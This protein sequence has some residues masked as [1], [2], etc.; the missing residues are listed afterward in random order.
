M[1]KHELKHHG[2]KGQKWG[3]RRYQNKDG[4]LTNAGKNRYND[5]SN[6]SSTT[7]KKGLTDKQ[8]KYLKIGATAVGVGLAAY[9]V[10]R[11]KK[12]GKL[13]QLVGKGKQYIEGTV[14][15]TFSKK[16]SSSSITKDLKAVNPNFKTGQIGYRM[17]CGNCSIAYEMR[18]RGFDTQALSNENGMKVASFGE[19][20]KGLKS[21]SFCELSDSAKFDII[22][23]DKANS[24]DSKGTLLKRKQLVQSSIEKTMLKQYPSGSRGTIYVPHIV[25]G[26][27]A[28][29][30]FNW[31]ILDGKVSFTDAQSASD[32]TYLFG[33]FNN[34][35]KTGIKT[36]RLDDLEPNYET[37][38]KVIKGSKELHIDS[39]E[40]DTYRLRGE[41]FIMDTLSSTQRKMF[42]RIKKH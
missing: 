4:T 36:I 28:A 39:K 33:L 9:G 11:L 16:L 3:V 40:F 37:L 38:N 41:S 13:D 35:D 19:Y 34:K 21:E 23:F 30:F 32:A 27:S 14:G 20:F 42:D 29:H 17:N 10:Y 12:S 2:I 8:K 1:K 15:S 24:M 5:I 25:G 22:N 18:R 6:S 26:R 7:K 31:S